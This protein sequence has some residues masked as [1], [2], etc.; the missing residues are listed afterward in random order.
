VSNTIT[1]IPKTKTA[2]KANLAEFIRLCREDLTVYNKN[3][4]WDSWRWKPDEDNRK[5]KGVL[6]I[7]SGIKGV[8]KKEPEEKNQLSK[9]LRDVFKAYW[10]Y[11]CGNKKRSLSILVTVFRCID[12]A[13]KELNRQPCILTM[14]GVIADE[15]ERIIQETYSQS[16][17]RQM[18]SRLQIFIEFIS[19]KGLIHTPFS[20]NH[21]TKDTRVN[22]KT[23]IEGRRN[24]EKKRP[25]QE[26]LDAL[27]EI[28]ANN[29]T[30]DYT[31]FT[32]ATSL[33]MLSQPS[34]I[35]EI[36][37]LRFDCDDIPKEYLKYIDKDGNKNIGYGFRYNAEK[38]YDPEIKWIPKSMQALAKEA[39]SRIIEMTQPARDYALMMEELIKQKNPKFPRHP[40]CPKVRDDQILTN[41]Q[42]GLALGMTS[43][44]DLKD[45]YREH[46]KVSETAWVNKTA[47]GLIARVKNTELS[48][49]LIDRYPDNKTNKYKALDEVTLNDLTKTLINRLPKDFPWINKKIGLRWSNALYCMFENQ[50]DLADYYS[51]KKHCKITTKIWITNKDALGQRLGSKKHSI[52]TIHGYDDFKIN[53]HMFRHYLNTIAQHG[54]TQNGG[55]TQ[56]EIAKW[57]GR[58]NITQNA[59]YNHTTFQDDVNALKHYN[60]DK[61]LFGG[62][63]DIEINMPITQQDFLAMERTNTHLSEFGVC[64][65]NWS[66]SSCEKFR[67]CANCELEV[68]IKGDLES[69]NRLKALRDKEQL[70]ISREENLINS[71]ELTD[72]D[73]N[74]LYHKLKLLRLNEKIEILESDLPDGSLVRL[75]NPTE[76]DRLQRA[77]ISRHKNGI[78]DVKNKLRM[79]IVD[80]TDKK[81]KAISADKHTIS[82]FEEGFKL[83]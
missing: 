68:C 64:E 62:S 42:I 3:L 22:N 32:T 51:E 69:L 71:G 21:S 12:K 43:C 36:M 27:A 8:S 53:S 67:D 24:R 23:G 29:Y 82:L 11:T 60:M 4:N 45:K 10:R 30:D 75:K 19:E 81:T 5:F 6:W 49:F 77:I 39:L 13:Y 15:A 74:Y 38:G 1:F 72:E 14:D 57:S 83:G 2:A 66:T 80:D 70:I 20:W 54:D 9:G 79:Q 59:V 40:L 73:Q 34:R 55:M 58:K 31:R 25:R 28:Y 26:A 37:Q 61:S 17:A 33:L 41:E 44:V 47:G 18:A 7:V 63:L 56:D 78:D 48:A 16:V 35:G 76:I 65:H 50:L 52:F 46:S